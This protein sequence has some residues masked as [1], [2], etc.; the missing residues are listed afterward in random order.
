[1]PNV[2]VQVKLFKAAVTL[3]TA[4]CSVPDTSTIVKPPLQCWY[5]DTG[6]DSIPFTASMQ[7]VIVLVKCHDGTV[8]IRVH[9]LAAHLGCCFFLGGCRNN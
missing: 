7:V 6:Y 3:H 5:A 9:P 2:L 1:M 8:V 4:P